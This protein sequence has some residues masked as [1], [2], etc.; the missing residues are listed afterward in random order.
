MQNYSDFENERIYNYFIRSVD[1]IK[2][3]TDMIDYTVGPIFKNGDVVSA[4]LNCN[5]KKPSSPFELDSY[6][7]WLH[8]SLYA[9]RAHYYCTID[10]KYNNIVIKDPHEGKVKFKG[11]IDTNLKFSD[12]VYGKVKK[13]ILKIP[14][15]L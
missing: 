4:S 8:Q 10:T 14:F 15:K 13:G 11:K 7:S 9:M 1:S 5:I 6:M 3:R 12:F 2:D